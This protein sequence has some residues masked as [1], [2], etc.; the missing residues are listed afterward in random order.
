MSEERLNERLLLEKTSQPHRHTYIHT[1]TT[2]SHIHAHVGGS[3]SIEA[4][5]RVS[6]HF[7][8]LTVFKRKEKRGKKASL[9]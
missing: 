1:H 3:R 9:Q 2:L 7:L 8:V 4:S 6:S 5:S